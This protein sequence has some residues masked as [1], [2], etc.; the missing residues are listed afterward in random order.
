[1]YVN[2]AAKVVIISQ[3]RRNYLRFRKKMAFFKLLFLIFAS[4]N[5]VK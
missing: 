5:H 2:E 3:L 4:Y 1:M